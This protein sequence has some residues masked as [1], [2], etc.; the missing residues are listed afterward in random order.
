[1]CELQ[2]ILATNIAESS[3]T[4]PDIRFGN[5]LKLLLLLSAVQLYWC[6]FDTTNNEKKTLVELQTLRAGC[7][8]AE[9]K[10]PHP[11]PQTPFPAAHDG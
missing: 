10:I 2:V 1:M 6:V 9:P 3:I 5:A 7:I 4:V 8:K 11:P